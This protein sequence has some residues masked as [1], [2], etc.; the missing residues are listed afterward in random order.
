METSFEL[1]V[2]TMLRYVVQTCAIL[3]DLL[4]SKSWDA[5]ITDFCYMQQRKQPRIFNSIGAKSPAQKFKYSIFKKYAAN[6]FD[7]VDPFQASIY[8]SYAYRHCHQ[9]YFYQYHFWH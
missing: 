6:F 2:L 4:W 3:N 1:A 9:L 5:V 7:A 8:V